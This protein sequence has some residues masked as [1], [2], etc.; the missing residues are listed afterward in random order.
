MVS[1]IEFPDIPHMYQDN[2]RSADPWFFVMAGNVAGI[3]GF[4]FLSAAALFSLTVFV[5]L[6]AEKIA[7]RGILFGVGAALFFITRAMLFLHSS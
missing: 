1:S 4:L 3:L 5:L 6:L 2:L 7:V